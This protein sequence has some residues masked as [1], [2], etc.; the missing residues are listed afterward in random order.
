MAV[1]PSAAQIPCAPIVLR[2]E[3]RGSTE[4]KQ[5][6]LYRQNEMLETQKSLFPIESPIPKLDVAGSI[7]VSRSMFSIS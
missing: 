5:A 4:R 1:T 3:P 6:N 7:P 2:L